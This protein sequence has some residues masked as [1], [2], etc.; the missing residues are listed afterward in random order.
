MSHEGPLLEHLMHR[1]TECPPEFRFRLYA[2]PSGAFH[3]MDPAADLIVPEAVLADLILELGGR[4]LAEEEISPL[5]CRK[6]EDVAR[7]QIMLLGA[8]L[9]HDPWFRAAKRFGTP[10]YVTLLELGRD[11]PAYTNAE[12]IR[13]DVE[14]RE[15]FVR[16][17]LRGLGLVP[18]GETTEHAEDRL[19]S[20]SAAER[21]RVVKETRERLQKA[22]ELAEAMRRKEAEEAAAR[23]YRE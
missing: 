12:Q 16:L 3:S 22:R 23:A 9:L 14:R 17:C 1:L 13:E 2:G 10:A 21:A 20:V 11:L 6:D 15:E 5:R 19:R 7:L 8:W 4:P 18:K